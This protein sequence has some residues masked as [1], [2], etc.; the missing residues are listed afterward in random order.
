MDMSYSRV[1]HIM[2]H[3]IHFFQHVILVM[4][5]VG[6]ILFGVFLVFMILIVLVVVSY[7]YFTCVIELWVLL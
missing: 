7:G 5:I 4:F 1:F 2:R 3:S 6:V